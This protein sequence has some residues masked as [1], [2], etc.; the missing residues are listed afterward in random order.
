MWAKNKVVNNKLCPVSS[1]SLGISLADAIIKADIQNEIFNVWLKGIDNDD[2]VQGSVKWICSEYRKNEKFKKLSERTRQDYVKQ[3]DKLCLFK[4]L[5]MEF[6]NF[7]ASD[8][9]PKHADKLYELMRNKFGDRQATYA[10][11]VAR[12]IWNI[13][14]RLDNVT[15][16]PFVQ[17]GLISTS[18]KETRPWSREEYEIFI[19]TAKKM[20]YHS[21]AVSARL[22]FE[23]CARE[24]DVIG[25]FYWAD[26]IPRQKIKY[27][28]NKTG[29]IVSI[30]LSDRDGLLFP[31]LE[32]ELSN[33]PKRGP[34]IVMRDEPDKKRKLHLPYQQSWFVH[35]IQKIRREA[36]LPD[37]LKFMGL[38]H[39]GA[40]E[41]SDAGATDREIISTT[42]HKTPKMLKIYSRKTETQASNAARKRRVLM[43]NRANLSE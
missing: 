10:M 21:I 15:K 5:K 31:E 25:S 7:Q 27:K 12:R 18:K 23:L 14:I 16:N 34:L 38:R 41:L 35:L 3:I 2:M 43:Q 1:T 40:T 37:E 4:P 30:P 11:Q 17:M 24:A 42:G 39:G 13:N 22:A 28:Q 19:K 9:K 33:T 36:G 6:G 29:V 8:V 20:G 26:Y 32:E